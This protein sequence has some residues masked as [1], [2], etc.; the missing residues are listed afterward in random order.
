VTGAGF[1]LNDEMDDFTTDPGRPNLFGLIQGEANAVA[2][3]KRMLSSMAPT[4]VL[5]A[6]GDVRAVAGARGGPRIIS[7]TW[8]VVSNIIDFGMDAQHAVNA[9]RLHQQWQPDQ[10]FLEQGGFFPEQIAGLES[11]GHHLEHVPDLAS[12][13]LILRDPTTGEWTG[14]PDPRRGGAAEGR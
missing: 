14:A 5:D 1:L 11:R 2:P 7:A 8:Q 12:A 3:N 4:L 9:P 10:V 6:T 13:P